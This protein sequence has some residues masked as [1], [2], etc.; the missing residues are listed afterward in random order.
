MD[1]PMPISS[2]LTEATDMGSIMRHGPQADLSVLLLMQQAAS[3]D[4]Q[5]QA[6]AAENLYRQALDLEPD[7]T[8][9]L[10]ALARIALDAN[11]LT[12][13]AELLDRAIA[14]GTQDADL[15]CRRGC[16]RAALGRHREALD[17][18]DAAL[19]F[20]G[21]QD[22]GDGHGV[23]PAVLQRQRIDSLHHLH[24]NH[25]ALMALEPL[26]AGLQ[27]DDAAE[28]PPEDKPLDEASADITGGSQAAVNH[29]ATLQA[30]GSPAQPPHRALQPGRG[31]ENHAGESEP[32][33]LHRLRANILAALERPDEA[34]ASYDQALA[35]QP[36]LTEIMQ[37][38][39]ALLAALNRHEEAAAGFAAAVRIKPNMPE[40][41]LNEGLSR[42]AMGDFLNGW[43][44]Y[45]WRWQTARLGQTRR[46]FE[47]PLWLGSQS[48]AGKTILL[49]AEQAIEDTIQFCRYARRAA[50][51]GASVLLEA[52]LSMVPLLRG[53]EGVA[54]VYAEGQALPPFDYHCPL[55][56]LPLAFGTTLPTIPVDTCYLKAQPEMIE[57]WQQRLS[58][59]PLLRVGLHWADARGRNDAR[60]IALREFVRLV[61]GR[62]QYVC[63]QREI[64][65]SDLAV[66]EQ[67]AEIRRIDDVLGDPE[68]DLSD[69]AALI[70]SLDLVIATESVVAHLAAAMG[71][72][73]WLL[74]SSRPGWRW[75]LDRSDSPWYPSV[76]LFRQPVA[77][78]WE[79]VVS[80][81]ARE[82]D[83]WRK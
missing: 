82:L 74:L 66:L 24:R 14:L 40:V 1:T 29:A 41:H 63:L 28:A 77:H 62:A 5:G 21:A 46:S 31:T 60:T 25:E 22:T 53:L 6:A 81:V 37:E 72:P 26:L 55:L 32:A 68:T 47:E 19:A 15:Y 38:R 4:Q 67:H 56:S 76:R 35:L 69:L 52:P 51:L 33:A 78:D 16:A 58:A 20:Y 71:K 39:A 64:P 30:P 44:K 34:L 57:P 12:H 17:D 59:S 83:R 50:A 7:N 42:L 3:M 73:V 70:S 23:A 11:R 75:M 9:A 18:F 43:K 27:T 79:V 80:T 10:L 36:E 54:G 61:Y 2:H 8:D 49:H 45:E 13:A 65:L 48:L